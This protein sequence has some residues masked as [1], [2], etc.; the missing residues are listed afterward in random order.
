MRDYQIE[1]VHQALVR[2]RMIVLSPTGSGKSAILYCIIRWLLA[3]GEK[4]ML[5]VP[6]TSLVTQMISDF[7]DY[8][9][10]SEPGVPVKVIGFRPHGVRAAARDIPEPTADE[11]AA[12]A[13]WVAAGVGADLVTVV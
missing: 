11:R 4:I 8:A 12:Y 3:R 6:T 10:D 9:F 13:A 7:K 2:K 1:A 5:A